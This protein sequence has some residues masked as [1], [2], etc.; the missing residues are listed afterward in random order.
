MPIEIPQDWRDV[1][2]DFKK[3]QKIFEHARAMENLIVQDQDGIK[4][5][6]R[7][8]PH[9]ATIDLSPFQGLDATTGTVVPFAYQDETLAWYNAAAAVGG[10]FETN[11]LDIADG[12]IIALKATTYF[13][14]I[15]YL[16][17][18][19]GS[20]LAAQLYPLRNLVAASNPTNVNFVAGDCTQA[21]GL[22]GNGSSKYLQFAFK[23]NSTTQIGVPTGGNVVGGFGY[24]EKNVDFGGTG[25]EPIG[26]YGAAGAQR[27][28]IDL[29]SNVRGIRWGGAG[30]SFAGD[31]TAAGNAFY[32][33]VRASATSREFWVNGS[34]IGTSTAN[35]TATGAGDNLIQ[36]MGCD[37]GGTQTFWKGRCAVAI[38]V[39]STFTSADV[40]SLYSILQTKL[41]TPTGR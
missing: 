8:S 33:G 18:F 13:Y 24:W 22:Q 15:Q 29:R 26:C 34:S 27:F 40:A 19:L 31:A 20:N 9:N 10:T 23:P 12:L 11:S 38:V 41:M 6:I 39:D 30:G 17:P 36:L 5:P 28:C 16:M 21:T 7:L 14:K 4:R 1:I 35:E 3:V 2:R 25:V 32:M 37:E